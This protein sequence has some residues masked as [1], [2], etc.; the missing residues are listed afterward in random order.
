M[1]FIVMVKTKKSD[2]VSLSEISQEEWSSFWRA[3]E[4]KTSSMVNKNKGHVAFVACGIACNSQKNMLER[5]LQSR[6]HLRKKPVDIVDAKDKPA[7][8]C[9]SSPQ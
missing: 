7:G 1:Q 3:I 6:F 2:E 4:K 8:V 5:I 9:S